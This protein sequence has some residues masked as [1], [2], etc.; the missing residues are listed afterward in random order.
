MSN[1]SK[2]LQRFISGSLP[3]DMRFGE[4]E[5]VLADIGY[6]RDNVDGD[7]F[8]YLKGESIKTIVAERGRLVAKFYLRR[9][10]ENVLKW[11]AASETN[12]SQGGSVP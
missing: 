3:G 4:V 11:Q 2:R 10:R 8:V 12:C 9:V 1:R 6:T 7:H 5:H